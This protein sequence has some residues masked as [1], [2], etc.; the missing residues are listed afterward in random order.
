MR[1]EGEEEEDGPE[2]EEERSRP[3]RNRG[4]GRSLNNPFA[5][6]GA[7]VAVAAG[8]DDNGGVSSDQLCRRGRSV[9]W[10][11]IAL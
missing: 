4:D 11:R 10:G 9:R 8:G 3:L 1:E 5:G 2:E 7:A 6:V